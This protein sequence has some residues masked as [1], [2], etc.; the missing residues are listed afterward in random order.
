[1]AD[2]AVATITRTPEPKPPEPGPPDSPEPTA[3]EGELEGP[4]DSLEAAVLSASSDR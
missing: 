1:M 2:E 3:E 4:P